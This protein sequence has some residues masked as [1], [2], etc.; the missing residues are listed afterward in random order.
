MISPGQ[1]FWDRCGALNIQNPR[2]PGMAKPVALTTVRVPIRRVIDE[3][4][5]VVIGTNLAET[6]AERLSESDLVDHQVAIITDENVRP[7]MAET[8]PAEL[9]ARGRRVHVVAFPAGERYKT[10]QTKATVEDTLIEAGC[11]RDTCILAVG[12]GVV[13]DLAG[14]VAAT[15]IR[16]VPFINVPTTIL[17]AADASIGGKTGVDTPAATNLVGVFHQP[18]AVYIDFAT[19]RTLPPEQIRNGLAETIKYACLADNDFFALLETVFVGQGRA[20]EE[21][22][23]DI[24]LMRQVAQRNAKIKSRFVG[25]DVHEFNLQM[26]LNLGHTFGRALEAAE[27]YTVSHGRAVAIGLMLQAQWG[28][29]LGFVTH[30]VVDRLKCLLESVALPTALPPSTT[31][32]Q[33]VAKMLHDKKALGRVVRFVFQRGIGDIQTFEQGSVVRPAGV[34]GILRF[35]VHVRR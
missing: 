16:G 9:A 32:E 18:R 27:D 4:Y 25:D 20:P 30:A 6:I 7:G 22:V 13:T 2:I 23:R 15:L 26:A 19:W 12:G 14:F 11:G 24:E 29:E 35:L 5:P 3:S 21:L 31:N 10:R 34:E 17:A 33:L 28:V 1:E 8:I